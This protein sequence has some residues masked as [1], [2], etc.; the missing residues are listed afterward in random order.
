[1]SSWEPI[2]NRPAFDGGIEG[3]PREGE[4]ARLGPPSGRWVVLAMFGFGIVATAGLWTYWELHTRPFRALQEAIVREFP[5]SNPRVQGGRKKMHKGTPRVLQVVMRVRFDPVAREDEASR[6]AARVAELA[7]RH[8]D[9]SQYDTV[10]IGLFRPVAEQ[11]P[12]M[13]TIR[14]NASEA[15]GGSDG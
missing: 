13:R 14:F 11:D 10:E 15:G 3:T 12:R 5:E 8:Q 4:S 9:L 7:A 2:E 1:M 6:V